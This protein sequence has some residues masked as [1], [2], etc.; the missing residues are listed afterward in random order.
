LV[1]YVLVFKLSTACTGGAS[2]C[3]KWAIALYTQPMA[4]EH[5]PADERGRRHFD[6]EVAAA[7]DCGL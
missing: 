5:A 2:P 1:G 6:A 3:I 4:I 7:V